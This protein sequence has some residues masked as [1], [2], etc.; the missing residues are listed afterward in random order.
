LTVKDPLGDPAIGAN[1]HVFTQTPVAETR[2]VRTDANGRVVLDDVLAGTLHISIRGTEGS[3]RLPEMTL[4]N[5]ATLVLETMLRASASPSSA[6]LSTSVA[7][8]GVGDEGRTLEFSIRLVD[9]DDPQLSQYNAWGVDAVTVLPCVPDEANDLPRFRPDCVSAQDGFD[10]SYQVE[11]PAKAISVTQVALP[12]SS[13]VSFSA[14]VLLDQGTK[15]VVNDPG[16]RRLFGTK[17]FL[18][19]LGAGDGALLAAFASDGSETGQPAL[20]PVQPVTMYPSQDAQFTAQGRDYFDSIDALSAMEGGASPLYAA[21]DRMIDVTAAH[22]STGERRAIVVVTDGEDDT[23]G[24]RDACRTAEHAVIAKGRLTGVDIFTIALPDPSGW[25]NREA[26]ARLA[27]GS[28]AALWADSAEQLPMLL[29]VVRDLLDGSNPT[30]EARFRIQAPDAGTFQSGRSVLG[31][32]SLEVCPFDCTYTY[33]P[34]VVDI[35]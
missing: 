28:G 6:F 1:V 29:G 9:I 16:D 23:C 32:V 35:P 12:G 10:A 14:A 2:D 7:P 19:Q 3:R 13:P 25:A 17:H 21:I 34:F 30:I 26:L 18:A 11:G 33:V 5:R 4:A 8:G 15:V 31:T 22:A 20:L 27:S 24:T